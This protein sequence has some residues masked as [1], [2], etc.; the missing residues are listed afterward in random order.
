MRASRVSNKDSATRLQLPCAQATVSVS[1]RRCSLL[2]AR[3]S[4]SRPADSL[5]P[6]TSFHMSFIT[7]VCFPQRENGKAIRDGV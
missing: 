7:S 1:L 2:V 6:T 3:C 5:L 4:I